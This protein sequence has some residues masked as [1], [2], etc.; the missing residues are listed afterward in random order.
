MHDHEQMK[1]VQLPRAEIIARLNDLLRQHGEGGIVLVTRGVMGLPGFDAL[2]LTKAL[3][4]YQAFDRD[5]NPHGE[6]DFG[7]LTL[8]GH[9]L[10]FKIDYYDNELKFGTDDPADAEI[11]RRVLT[12][13]LAA[14]W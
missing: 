13:M 3:A 10:L 7:D 2:E 9:D 14:D 1:G 8:W 4:N 11:T 6:R 5:N 12:V